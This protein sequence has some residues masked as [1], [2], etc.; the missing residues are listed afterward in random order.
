MGGRAIEVP[1]EARWVCNAQL[2]TQMHHY[3]RRDICAISKGSYALDSYHN[4]PEEGKP[5]GEDPRAMLGANVVALAAV[6]LVGNT[7]GSSKHPVGYLQGRPSGA[8]NPQRLLMINGVIKDKWIRQ[9]ERGFHEG[10]D[11]F[12]GVVN[13]A[14]TPWL[15][16]S[17]PS[18]RQITLQKLH[19]IITRSCLRPPSLA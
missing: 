18:M 10:T 5:K 17:L 13:G 11:P 19:Q 7:E 9:K 16:I 6:E 1:R 14:G 15:C 8:A 4:C 12:R 2:S 3:A